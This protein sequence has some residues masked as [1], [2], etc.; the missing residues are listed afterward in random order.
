M[1]TERQSSILEL[2][3]R[4]YVD[5]AVPVASKAL[6]QRYGLSVSSATIR[7]EFAELE[8]QGYLQ[9]PHTSAGRVPTEKGYRYFVET[10]M[11]EEELSWQA[12]Q[13]IRHQFHQIEG[14]SESWV[15]LAS[16]VLARAV[17]NA[18][19]VTAPRSE[20]SRMKHIELV[21]LQETTALLV[22]VLDQARLKQQMLTLNESCT[23]DELSVMASRLNELFAGSSR[24]EI[25][26]KEATLAQADLPVRQA[27]RQVIDTVQEVMRAVDEGGF[28]EAH[29]EGL[30]LV[31]SQPEFSSSER[32]LALLELLDAHTLTRAIPFRALAGPGVTVVIGAENVR[33]APAGDAMRECS[34][35]VGSYGAPGIATGALAVLGPMRMHYSRT[36][37]TVRYLSSV[38]SELLAK[39]EA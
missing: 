5:S 34:V 38:M 25:A 1:L 9:Q 24:R 6:H 2:V 17:Q 8:E 33:L 21:S 36:I 10:L 15:H 31:L 7:N 37:S 28:D 4:D 14:G 18:A 11:R 16:S 39:Y 29:L 22:L 12:Q 19:V 26:A 13:T 27:G 23:Q 20:A 30:R 35:V 32:A 3:I